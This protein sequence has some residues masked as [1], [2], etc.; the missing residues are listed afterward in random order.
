MIG[1]SEEG[2][3]L[4]KET[5]VKKLRVCLAALVAAAMILATLCLTGC[6]GTTT[7]ESTKISPNVKEVLNSP[8]F[9]HSSWTIR[10]VDLETGEKVY[11]QLGP[12][13]ML[14]PASNTKLYTVA[15]TFDTLGQ[16]YRFETP[17][18]E[19]GTVGA[20]G[21]LDGNLILVASGDLVMGGRATAEGGID[22]TA[23]D[24]TDAD[25]L[26]RRQWGQGGK[27]RCGN[28]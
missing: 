3:T 15:T 20:S 24:H 17:V 4:R 26:G 13:R 22:Y 5:Q 12:N 27:R 8:E 1:W 14:D 9:K 21:Q 11:E 2:T 19:Q 18:Y 23:M 16:D 6:D 25:A 10:V 28:R 7:D